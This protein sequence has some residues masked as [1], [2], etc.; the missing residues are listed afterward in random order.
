MSCR[1]PYHIIHGALWSLYAVHH[2]EREIVLV[3]VPADN[4][5]KCAE[6]RQ[7]ISVLT[8]T[9]CLMSRPSLTSAKTATTMTTMTF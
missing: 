7:R 3:E 4:G 8:V 6:L 5:I 2:L 9:E 1:I